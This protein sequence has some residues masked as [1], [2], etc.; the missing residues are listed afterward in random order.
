MKRTKFSP[1]STHDTSHLCDHDDV[2]KD[3]LGEIWSNDECAY[4]YDAK[5]ICSADDGSGTKLS[6][7]FCNETPNDDLIVCWISN[8]G[9]PYHFRRIPCKGKKTVCC[10]L[11]DNCNGI[12]LNPLKG[13][14]H[15][16][17]EHTQLGHAFVIATSSPN[18]ND[19]DDNDEE[20]NIS[21]T[22]DSSLII[23]AYR[24]TSISLSTEDDLLRETTHIVTISRHKQNF[25]SK[26]LRHVASLKSYSS[27][28]DESLYT[29]QVRCRQETVK[30]VVDTR[31]KKY[32][33]VTLGGW[34]CYCE[35]GWDDD[36][37]NLQ[38]SSSTLREKL[39]YHIQ[40]AVSKIPPKARELLSKSTPIYINKSQLF[41]AK[42][43]PSCG[44]GMC[45]HPGRSW[46]VEMGMNPKKANTVE[47]YNF[48]SYFDDCDLWHLPGGVILHE[49][50]HAWHCAH[51]I[52]GYSNEDVKSCYEMSVLHDDLYDC[53][54]VHGPQGPK[55]RAYACQD[56]MEY[57]AE[58]SV[59][60]LSGHG[61]KRATD[62]LIDVDGGN[63]STKQD[64]EGAEYNKWFPFNRSQLRKH[65]PRAYEMM[66]RVW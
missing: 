51:V 52:N 48:R 61:Q 27:R 5:Q 32:H 55:C 37:V 6:V 57:F 9:T 16:H 65:D 13:N 49:L 46:L 41:G 18:D 66:Q 35:E 59:A 39:E 4:A 38:P 56:Q 12:K 20:E 40:I 17:I 11:F 33:P 43:N 28:H 53:V 21:K 14:R 19:T 42:S 34:Q 64:I 1:V 10:G 8:D 63:D 60:F 26:F 23:A 62:A 7:M 36:D 24:P 25:F 22:L 44:H 3:T 15:Q 29:V 30:S 31:A 45:Y 50:A 2:K 47:L 58:L 54:E